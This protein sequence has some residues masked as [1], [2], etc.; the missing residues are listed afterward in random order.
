DLGGLA[1]LAA[2]LF[3]CLVTVAYLHPNGPVEKL[4]TGGP[5]MLDQAEVLAKDLVEKQP[6]VQQAGGIDAAFVV[7]RT[8]ALLCHLAVV[9]GLL[10]V[11]CRHFQHVHTGMA[12]ATFYLLLPYT[13]YHIGQWHPVRPTAL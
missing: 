4:G 9:G 11:G 2:A 12:A 8:L 5:A 10:Y 13:A 3:V 7:S 1:W 6:A